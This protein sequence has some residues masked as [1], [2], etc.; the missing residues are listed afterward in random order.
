[1]PE[2]CCDNCELWFAELIVDP[3]FTQFWYCSECYILMYLNTMTIT[4][5]YK[6]E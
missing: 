2:G 4:D 1:M 5:T 6:N 3:E